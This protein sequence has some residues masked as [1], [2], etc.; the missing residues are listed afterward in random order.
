MSKLTRP[1]LLRLIIFMAVSG[2]FGG[3]VGV[4]RGERRSLLRGRTAA[5]P[6]TNTVSTN[7]MT[8]SSTAP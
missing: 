4:G 7:R 5:R 2:A 1:Y 8:G 3:A 6:G